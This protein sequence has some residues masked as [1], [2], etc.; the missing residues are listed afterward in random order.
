MFNELEKNNL[1]NNFLKEIEDGSA[2][3]ITSQNELLSIWK[4]YTLFRHALAHAGGRTTDRIKTKME[5]VIQKNRKELENVNS[6]MSIELLEEEFF[7]SPFESTV[8]SIT[9]EHLNFFRNTAILIIESLERAIHPDEYKVSNF[10]PYK[11]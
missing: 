8:I 6:M 11:L 5:E 4:Y 7:T 1:R 10:N 9:D 2:S 3:I